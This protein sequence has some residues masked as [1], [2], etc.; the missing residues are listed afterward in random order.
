MQLTGTKIVSIYP[1]LL[2]G[3]ALLISLGFEFVN[4]FTAP[5]RCRPSSTG[6]SATSSK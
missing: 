5:S 3:V 4:G 6:S 2:L 1:F